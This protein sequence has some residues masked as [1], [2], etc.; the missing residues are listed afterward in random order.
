M[1][2]KEKT[3]VV[4]LEQTASDV[5]LNSVVFFN[6]MIRSNDS[7]HCEG[8]ASNPILQLCAVSTIFLVSWF[9]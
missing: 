8:V 4:E 7:L 2:E 6:K 5:N 3:Y 9:V 1:K